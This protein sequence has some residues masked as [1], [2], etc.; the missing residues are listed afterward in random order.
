MNKEDE[1]SI[2]FQNNGDYKGEHINSLILSCKGSSEEIDSA[3]NQLAHHIY[4]NYTNP[5]V[6]SDMMEDKI[7][8]NADGFNGNNLGDFFRN[9]CIT[10]NNH[11]LSSGY[12]HGGKRGTRYVE[13][14]I[15][16]SNDSPFSYPNDEP[17]IMIVC[18]YNK[19]RNNC[20]MDKREGSIDELRKHQKVVENI[21]VDREN[22][23]WKNENFTENIKKEILTE[24]ENI[25]SR[26]T[27]K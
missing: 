1:M 20:F 5:I 24:L 25:K 13:K 19:G 3:L 7:L 2:Y 26:I 6:W 8:N 15:Y 17:I 4:N 16:E 21:I 9:N 14:P 10:I 11:K 22:N 12:V 27:I 23:R 18:N